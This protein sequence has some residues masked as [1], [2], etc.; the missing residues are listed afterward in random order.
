MRVLVL[1]GSGMLGRAVFDFLSRRTGRQVWATIRNEW[2][3]D[4]L[5]SIPGNIVS[6]IDVQD[7]D[8][9][10]SSVRDIEPDVVINCIGVVK[11][12]EAAND[13]AQ[14]LPINS[15]FP[16]QLSRICAS[17]HSRLIHI[18]TDCV[19]SGRKGAYRETDTSDAEDLYGKSKYLGEVHDCEH[20]ITLRTSVIGHEVK[21]RHSLVDWFLSQEGTV[22]GYSRVIFS[23]LPAI[24]LGRVINDR[25]LPRP[26][27]RGLYHVSSSPISKYEL[28]KS[29][30]AVYKKAIDLQPSDQPVSDRSLNSDRFRMATG[31]VAPMWPELIKTMYR[32]V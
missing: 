28:L 2:A 23:G 8:L 24:E 11:Q 30:A 31:Y 16:H 1:G 17:T 26:K 21:T 22:T 9:L 7:I 32:N 13:P 6:G 3:R 19:F 27:L 15:I 25:V 12:L 29:I 14:I 20:V 4:Y 10:A 18:S 5:S